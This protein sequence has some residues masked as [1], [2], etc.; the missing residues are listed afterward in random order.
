MYECKSY[1]FHGGGF[2]NLPCHLFPLNI[3]LLPRWAVNDTAHRNLINVCN[4]N[5]ER[6]R[7]IYLDIHMSRYDI[8]GVIIREGGPR[9]AH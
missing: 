2:K 1:G 8:A 4:H 9:S 3:K 7:N 6:K 5:I